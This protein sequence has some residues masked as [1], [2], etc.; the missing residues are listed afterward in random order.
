MS[1]AIID[2]DSVMFSIGNGNKVLGEDGEPLKEDGKFVYTPKTP[3]QLIESADFMMN[4]ILRE[5]GA[6]GYVAYIKGK[7]TTKARIEANAAYKQNR[8]KES[9]SWW[10]FVKE[11]LKLSWG[12]VEAN[13]L[14]VD[15][16][17]N[18]TRKFI[19]DSFITAIDKDLLN[20]PG[21]HYNWREGTWTDEI[22]PEIADYRFWKDMITGQSGDNIKGIPGKGEKFAEKI[23]NDHDSYVTNVVAAYR[24]AFQDKWMDEFCKNYSSLR[25]LDSHDDFV[26]ANPIMLN[27]KLTADAPVEK[28]NGEIESLFT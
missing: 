8:P 17:V 28:K 23:L 22:T 15:D 27:V 18:I 10:N 16:A 7:N 5:S 26:P 4:K 20:L 2:M 19:K 6:T 1:I 24:D 3:H 11:Y 25:I 13:G 14:E 21:K 12:V 9:P